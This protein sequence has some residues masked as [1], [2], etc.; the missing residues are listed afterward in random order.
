MLTESQVVDCGSIGRCDRFGFPFGPRHHAV[1]GREANT[2]SLS[3]GPA[4]D[5]VRISNLDRTARSSRLF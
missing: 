2:Q 1:I 3:T 4:C 5:L